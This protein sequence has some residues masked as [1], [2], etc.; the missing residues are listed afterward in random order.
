MSVLVLLALEVGV[1]LASEQ[2]CFCEKSQ[3]AVSEV[4]IILDFRGLAPKGQAQQTAGWEPTQD[5]LQHV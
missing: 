4:R 2:D 1:V 5:W 3:A